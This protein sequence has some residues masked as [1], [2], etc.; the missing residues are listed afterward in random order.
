MAINS[1]R[2]CW[3]QA[4]PLQMMRGIQTRSAADVARELD[5]H[6]EVHKI[7]WDL[8]DLREVCAHW[9]PRNLTDDDKAHCMGL[10]GPFLYPLDMLHRSKGAVLKL[11]DG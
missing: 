7:V 11:K 6:W 2:T 10:Y 8:L 4:R 5:I 1:G 3:H 9:V